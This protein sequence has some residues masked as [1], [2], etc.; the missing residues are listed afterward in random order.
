MGHTVYFICKKWQ[1]TFYRLYTL[2]ITSSKI[3]K[4]ILL[5]LHWP[6]WD[7]NSTVSNRI[8]ALFSLLLLMSNSWQINLFFV[9]WWELNH[10]TRTSNDYVHKCWR[11]MPQVGV[12]GTLINVFSSNCF[13]QVTVW[14]P[15]ILQFQHNIRNHEKI[16]SFHFF[17]VVL[18]AINTDIKH[19]VSTN[20]EGNTINSS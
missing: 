9:F 14:I 12:N 20:T 17:V 15:M 6:F 11:D 7:K 2:H 16:A 19:L 10:I 18:N 5:I 13:M 1:I 3:P 8:L 4:W